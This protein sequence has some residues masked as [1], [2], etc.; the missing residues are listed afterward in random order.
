MPRPNFFIIGAPK[1]GTTAL[2]R[3]LGRHSQVFVATPKEPHYFAPDLPGYRDV[4]SR[5]AYE[6]LFAPAA[7][8]QWRL[9]EASVFYLYSRESAPRIRRYAPQ[10]RIIALVRNPLDLLPSFHSQLL[11]SRDEDEPELS[12][13]WQLMAQRRAGQRIPR[14]C[15]APELL[16]YDRF[17]RLGEQLERWYDAFTPEQIHVLF[18]E[19]LVANTSTELARLLSFLKLPDEGPRE[20]DHVNSRRAHRWSWLADFTQR[21]PQPLVNAALALKNVAGI[22][23]LGVL[24][25]LRRWNETRPLQAPLESW[26]QAAIAD[27]Y[28]DDVARL[29]RLTGR[30]LSHWLDPNRLV[31]PRRVGE[32]S[33]ELAAV[34]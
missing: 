27:C 21:T 33:Q 17:A 18:F 23:R 15:R 30:D 25:A 26:L 9:G 12:R 31:P 24:D 3:F 5:E 11:Y 34:R 4:K 19:D 13:A 22:K 14:H 32:D 16:R 7:A 1:C 8:N 28:A 6:Q 20:L 10:A 2:H 29:G